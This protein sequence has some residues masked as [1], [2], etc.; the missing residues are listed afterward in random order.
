M[1]DFDTIDDHFATHA[2]LLLEDPAA[3]LAAMRNCSFF[4]PVA[5]EWLTRISEMAQITTF[6]PDT[7]ITSQDEDMKAFYVI[8]YGAAEAFR[9]GKLVGAIETGDCFGEGIFFTDG[10][11]STS[12]TVIAED[13]II[14]AEFSKSAIEALQSDPRAMVSMDKALLLALFKKLKGANQKI[15]RLMLK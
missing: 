5:D 15:E 9:N 11:V 8:L 4:E 13:K 7:S 14:A 2:K 10:S 1:N 3:R 12:A 6:E